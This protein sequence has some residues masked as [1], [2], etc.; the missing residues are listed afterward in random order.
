MSATIGA[1]ALECPALL[2]IVQELARGTSL[3]I[4]YA[5]PYFPARVP[6]LPVELEPGAPISSGPK[7]L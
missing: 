7:I 1:L 4:L 6:I 2:H 3:V 5:G